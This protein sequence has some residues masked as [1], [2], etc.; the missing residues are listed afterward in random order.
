MQL[1]IK[2]TAVLLLVGF[3][4]CSLKLSAQQ[5]SY[6]GK[7]VQLASFFT[8]VSKQTGYLFFYNNTL[9]R[10]IPPVS[11][12]LKNVSLD[13]ALH[14]VFK[15]QCLTYYIQGRT[16]FITSAK[17][18]SAGITHVKVSVLQKMKGQVTDPS[19]IPIMG[20]TVYGINS[21]TSTITNENGNFQINALQKRACYSV[22]LDMAKK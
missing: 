8:S 18:E 7:T 3:T 9:L 22:A 17:I 1:C 6:T 20:A 19:G 16:V 15:N 21:N 10:D 13:S 11:V 5:V 12:R 4:L 2:R 14:V